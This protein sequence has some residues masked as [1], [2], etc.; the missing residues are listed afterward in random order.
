[1]AGRSGEFRTHLLEKA[2]IRSVLGGG[3]RLL[4]PQ[5]PYLIRLGGMQD[6]GWRRGPRCSL[7]QWRGAGARHGRREV[8]YAGKG[9]GSGVAALARAMAYFRSFLPGE[10][11][12]RDNDRE[13]KLD[14]Y[15]EFIEKKLIPE[16]NF[17]DIESKKLYHRIS[18][19]CRI[20]V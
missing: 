17:F 13:E 15:R 3:A 16:R 18:K 11:E 20:P 8:Y 2:R 6:N 12:N 10:M 19:W 5:P 4:N 7:W 9:E 1:M 14:K